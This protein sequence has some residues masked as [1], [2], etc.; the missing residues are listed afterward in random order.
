MNS[1]NTI[2]IDGI[3]YFLTNSSVFKTVLLWE[4]PNPSS[5]FIKQKISIPN[6]KDYQIFLIYFKV[7]KSNDQ[8]QYKV[9]NL[10]FSIKNVE[11]CAQLSSLPQTTTYLGLIAER[12]FTVMDDGIDFKEGG[13]KQGGEYQLLDEWMIPLK[14]YGIR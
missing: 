7:H 10:F 1:I 12:R 14:V 6:V 11:I 3:S 5:E 8:I 2:N 13:M 4:N 9:Y